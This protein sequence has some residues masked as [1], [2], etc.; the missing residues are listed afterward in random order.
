VIIKRSVFCEPKNLGKIKFF[1]KKEEISMNQDIR[2]LN[3]LLLCLFLVMIFCLTSTVFAADKPIVLKLSDHDT[4]AGLKGRIGTLWIEE[5]KKQTGGKVE[6]EGY[7]G[8]ALFSA[9]EELKALSDGVVDIAAIYPD[10]YPN[11]LPFFG[12]YWLFPKGPEKWENIKW[13][14]NET[15]ARVPEFSKELK[16]TGI[17]ILLMEN[18][19]PMAFMSRYP[20]TSLKDLKGK[21]WRAGDRWNLKLLGNQGC[22]VI[23]VP[24][25]DCYMALQTGTVDGIVSNYDGMHRQKFDEPAK[26][27]LSGKAI[28]WSQPMYYA[29]N[30]KKWDSIPKDLQEGILE[31]S[32]IAEEAFGD[33]YD[34]EFDKIVAEE[35][36][37]GCIVNFY[38]PEDVDSWADESC[39]E[40]LRETFSNELIENNVTDK[41]PEMLKQ[42]SEVINEAIE[43]EK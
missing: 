6:I 42:I 2:K 37:S 20:V 14:Y 30:Q 5:V 19:L 18:G 24:W 9:E 21:K 17:K 35:K 1:K 4:N 28:G 16:A 34:A 29:I 7:W 12:A 15:M 22:V 32:R 10:F 41:G 31:A 8:G 23:S 13:V 43:R 40:G 11:Q 39:L 33:M 27:I 38:S 26:N 3:I 36:E 25:S